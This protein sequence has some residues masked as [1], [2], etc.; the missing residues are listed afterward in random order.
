MAAL[1]SREHTDGALG[2]ASDPDT[3]FLPKPFM[4][5]E[6]AGAVRALLEPEQEPMPAA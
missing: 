6:L 2:D 4:S 1:A 5:A 3:A